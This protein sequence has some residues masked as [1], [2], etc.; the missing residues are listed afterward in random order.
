MQVK[1]VSRYKQVSAGR[2]TEDWRTRRWR[3]KDALRYRPRDERIEAR[4]QEKNVSLVLSHLPPLPKTAVVKIE[5]L[6]PPSTIEVYAAKLWE[7]FRSR[8][9]AEP[10]DIAL[11]SVVGACGLFV[12]FILGLLA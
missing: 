11:L 7:R 3:R 6:Q 10:M 9:H 1:Y 8:I 5:N 12:G 2:M 4:I